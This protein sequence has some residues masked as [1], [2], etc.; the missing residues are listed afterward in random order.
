MMC[1]PAGSGKSIVALR[2]EAD[3][4]TRLSFDLEAWQRGILQMPLLPD[5]HAEIERELQERLVSLVKVGADVVLDF[6]FWSRQSRDEYRE[7][8]RS[9]GVVPEIMHLATPRSTVLERMRARGHGHADDYALPAAVVAEYFHHFEP[10]TS[11][12]G[13]LLILGSES[14]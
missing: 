12:E 4:M 5:V 7:L 9:I 6:A 10:P 13:P 11:D 1:G 2:L 14:R 8:L 3:G